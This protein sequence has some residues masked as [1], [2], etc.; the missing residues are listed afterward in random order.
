LVILGVPNA[1]ARG[2]AVIVDGKV[3]AAANEERFVR[4]KLIRGFPT[5]SIAWVLSSQGLEARDVDWVGA[6]CWKGIDQADTLPLL[7]RDILSQAECNGALGEVRNR[8]DVTTSRDRIFRQELF[9]GLATI[10]INPE[11]IHLC[12]HHY[13]HALTAFCP[14]PFDDALVLTA[15]GRGDFRSVALWEASRNGGLRLLD[16]ATELTSPGALYGFITKYLGFTPDRHEGKVTGLAAHGRLGPA[17]DLL[18]SAYDYDQREG[19]IKSR[20][21]DYYRP[22]VSASPPG[23]AEGLKGISREDVAFAVQKLLEDVLRAFLTRHISSQPAKSINLC[24]AGGCAS[25]VKLNYELASLP[26][27]R[28]VYVFPQ[29]GDGGCA[30]GGAMAVA[31]EKYGRNRFDMPTVYLGPGYDDGDIE[32][33]FKAEGVRYRTL[34]DEERTRETVEL[35]MA[36]RVVGWYQ[37]RMEYGPRALGNRTILAAATDAKINDVLNARLQRTEFMPFAPVTTDE[38]AVRC[39]ENWEP[40]QVSSRFMTICYRATPLLMERCPAIV[41]VDGTARPQVVF[42]EHNPRYYDVIKAYVEKTGNPAL[43]NTSFNHH[44][45]PI[46]HTPHDAVRCLRKGNVD[47]LVAGNVIAEATHL[48]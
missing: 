23:L 5:E 27:I 11:R 20:I 36:D 43:I 41:H 46:I 14:S 32:K 26:Q 31:L 37:G 47:V 45:E 40:D 18:R 3:V 12:D 13:A 6:G 10:G 8:I 19:R 25:N 9:D 1:A 44:E 48:T 28:G 7:V 33:V 39:F 42:R 2:A 24:L 21:G 4:K 16:S 17:Y 38:F 34:S 30:L 29:M 22:F 15:D 35:L